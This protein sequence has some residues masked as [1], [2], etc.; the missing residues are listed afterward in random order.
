[1]PLPQS[2][3]VIG[4]DVGGT[5]IDVALATIQGQVLDRIRIATDATAG[6][7]QALD[8]I[9]KLINRLQR[10]SQSD[11]GLD[12]ASV[13]AVIPGVVHDDRILLAPNLPGWE[14]VA[15]SR[16]VAAMAGLESVSVINDVKA[17]ALAEARSGGLRGVDPGLYV[18]LGTGVAAALVIGGQVLE[19]AHRAAGEV[20]YTIS[21]ASLDAAEPCAELEDRVG[22][23]V[24]GER[25]STIVGHPATAEELL[26]TEDP[27]ARAVVDRALSALATTLVNICALVD[28]HRIVLGGGLM[29]AGDQILP[30]LAAYLG[31]LVPF[32]PE[33]RPAAFG[34]DASLHGAVA[35]AIDSWSGATSTAGDQA[36]RAGSPSWSVAADSQPI[37]VQA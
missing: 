29:A 18:N 32:P 21:E 36:V 37:G 14:R 34:Q 24:L 15:L 5:K 35:L 19:G 6:P 25:W 7:D 20:A 9:G 23:R 22:G 8:R 10:S 2:L 30:P 26:S 28:P 13:A 4:V 27:A 12:V 31:R 11:F 16:E 1:M 3:S 33:L 17:A